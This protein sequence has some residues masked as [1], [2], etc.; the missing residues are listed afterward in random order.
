MQVAIVVV[1]PEVVARNVHRGCPLITDWLQEDDA[2]ESKNIHGCRLL[3]A[4]DWERYDRNMHK[5]EPRDYL[6]YKVGSEVQPLA[7]WWLKNSRVGQI[8]L[9]SWQTKRFC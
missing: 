2:V 6:G 1:R 9:H 8:M 7:S 4:E 5:H 3:S